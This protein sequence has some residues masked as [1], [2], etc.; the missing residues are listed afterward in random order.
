[1][2]G[3]V[4]QTK[5]SVK[6]QTY[7]LHGNSLAYNPLDYH[8]TQQEWIEKNFNYRKFFFH[9]EYGKSIWKFINQNRST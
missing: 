4:S 5:V 8:D 3:V 9:W 2:L 1:M 6:N 7:N